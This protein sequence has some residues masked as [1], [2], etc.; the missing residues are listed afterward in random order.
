MPILHYPPV[1]GGFEIF[2][3]NV[4]ERIGKTDDVFVVTSRVVNTPKKEEKDRLKIFRT[5][6]QVLKDLAYTKP[7]FLVGAM[8]WILFKSIIIVKKE[9][10]DLIHAQKSAGFLSGLLGYLLSKITKTPYII[11]IQS[12]DFSIYRPHL[13]IKIIKGISG[14]IEKATIKNAAICHS[15][16]NYLKKHLEKYSPG[17]IIVIPN[18]VNQGVFKPDFNKEETRKKLGFS[19]KNLIMAC[20]SRLENKNGTHDVIEAANYFKNDIGD[21]KVIVVGDG[22]DRKKIEAM[23]DKYE[24]KDR[25]F[26]LGRVQ[27]S[28]L[29]KLMAAC[30]IFIRPSLAEGFGI[31]FIEAMACGVGVIA[32]PVGG[33]V[34][35][36]KDRENGLFCE[37]GNPK[38]IAEKIK[39]LLVDKELFNRLVNNGLK[40]IKEEYNWDK[41]SEKI[42]EI[43][44]QILNSTS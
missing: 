17:K 32:T 35:F 22:P 36:L 1:I 30:D 23:V 27:Y 37:P 41:I 29:P 10:I 18:G 28:D 11:T 13:N 14:A 12:A 31:S 6:P 15:V 21:F 42:K 38:D 39:L 34:D 20:D 19:T 5:S 44:Q 33:I 8:I 24:L 43:Y 40:T 26:L 2:T 3:Q 25:V 7:W 16:S 9:K 4:A